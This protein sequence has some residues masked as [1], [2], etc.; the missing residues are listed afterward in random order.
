MAEENTPRG[1]QAPT[2]DA[3]PH[4]AAARTAPP[5][6]AAESQPSRWGRIDADGT[7]YVRTGDGERQ[8]GVWQA[9]PADEGLLHFAR[10]FDDLRTEV[11]LLETR[12]R[13]GAGEPKHALASANQL[14]DRIADAAVVGDIDALRARV[15]QVVAHAE[16]AIG[17]AK[18]QREQHRAA[19]IERKNALVAEAEQ[20]AAEST[21]WKHAGDRL[22]AIDRK[23]V[24]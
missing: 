5:V 23:S 7:V 16:R 14:R 24:V 17:E 9:G 2:P 3:V 22:R 21:Q 15:E 6:P 11:E 1:A 8:V 18:Q 20:I 4:A 10:R 12:I 13:S 19:A